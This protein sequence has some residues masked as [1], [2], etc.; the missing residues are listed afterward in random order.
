VFRLGKH[1]KPWRR[2]HNGEGMRKSE[3]RQEQEHFVLSL[4]YWPREKKARTAAD[5]IASIVSALNLP[6]LMSCVEI[7]TMHL[8][9]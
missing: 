8:V 5:S 6:P 9:L 1:R 4:F 3:L 7:T 2:Q